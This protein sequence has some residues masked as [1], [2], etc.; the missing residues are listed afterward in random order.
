VSTVNRKAHRVNFSLVFKRHYLKILIFGVL[1]FLIAAPV[2]Y[3]TSSK[4]YTAMVELRIDPRSSSVVLGMESNI[5]QYYSEYV[6][7]QKFKLL[8]KQTVEKAL[9]ALSPSD[10]NILL[11]GRSISE[12]VIQRFI[13]TIE[14][15][16]AGDSLIMTI[17]YSGSQPEGL[18]ELL[19]N[20]VNVYLDEIK[21]E[22][23]SQSTNRIDFSDKQRSDLEAQIAVLNS[24]IKQVSEEM[25]T[26]N[27]S[28][29]DIP[30]KAELKI[31]EEAAVRAENDRILKEKQYSEFVKNLYKAT[32]VGFDSA[33]EQRVSSD[34]FLNEQKRLL[35]SKM[36]AYNTQLSN[37]SAQNSGRK[38]LED[39]VAKLQAQL[40]DLESKAREKYRK[41]LESETA[42]NL[43]RQR[44]AL[45]NDY[46]VAKEFED[47]VKKSYK[48]VQE[49]YSFV[50]KRA[51]TGLSLQVDLTNLKTQLAK[52]NETRT[53]LQGDRQTGGYVT[54]ENYAKP[55]V[56]PDKSSLSKNI[57]IAFIVSFLWIV[58][59]VM[60]YEMMDQ[61]IK[62]AEELKSFTG[63]KPSWPISHHKAPLLGVSL[64][65]RESV[66]N[67]AIKSLAT[68]INQERQNFQVKVVTFSGINPLCGTT[69]ILL[70]C[71]HSMTDNCERILVVDFNVGR[72]G[73]ANKLAIPLKSQP[74]VKQLE[75][76]PLESLVFRDQERDIDVLTVRNLE[77]LENKVVDR[78]L[79]LARD[80]YDMVFLD[81]GPILNTSNTEHLFL[82]SDSAVFVVRGNNSTF[83]ALQHTME[84]AGK[85]GI[86]SAALVLNWWKN[87]SKSAKQAQEAAEPS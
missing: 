53:L 70:N 5:Q 64:H 11:G 29:E 71:A 14:V 33:V 36:D 73:I 38:E 60:L 20:L 68:R 63:I 52:V 80:R 50:S 34:N 78:V 9:R 26:G 47:A 17:S 40:V 23:Q 25:A 66:A 7:T 42:G 22:Q 56:L 74:T 21:A 62:S 48:N 1:T 84:L 61:R 82:Q 2:I 19:N 65:D 83:P 10:L 51:Q 4:S 69:E 77:S 37:L 31:Q 32:T 41:L 8:K 15:R 67:K 12:G 57:V 30:Y 86:Q 35:L 72:P 87:D 27:F 6:A 45:Y 16:P 85:F 58:G 28:A 18:A 43:E 24:Q 39:N 79:E 49:K 76:A 3:F 46:I 44:L 13:D 55:P 75:S 59:A 81:A 54:V